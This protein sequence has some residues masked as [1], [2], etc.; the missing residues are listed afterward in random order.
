MKY[1]LANMCINSY[2]ICSTAFGRMVKIGPVVFL[3]KI[4]VEGENCAVTWLKFDDHRP[5]DTL[6]S[7]TDWKIEILISA[8]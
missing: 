4:E 1:C 2:S 3:S 5:F 8:E 7:K 6:A